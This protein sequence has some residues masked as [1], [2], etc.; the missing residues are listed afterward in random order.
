MLLQ[1]V[2][3]KDVRF[4]LSIVIAI[5]FCCVYVYAQYFRTMNR[6]SGNV[7]CIE[8]WEKLSARNILEK[9]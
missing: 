5:D 9:H 8:R 7:C 3:V 1:E 6:F 4:F 2:R